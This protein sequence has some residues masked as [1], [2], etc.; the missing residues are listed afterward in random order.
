M[1]TT[2]HPYEFLARW[3]RNG[4]LGGAHVQFRYVTQADDGTV[5]GEFIGVAEPVAAGASAGF[6][7][8]E[9]LSPL[10]LAALAERDAALAE[11]DLLAARLAEDVAMP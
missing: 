9:I 1:Q 8:E 6:P 3:D 5:L 7:L 11:R 10:T 2:K 4:G